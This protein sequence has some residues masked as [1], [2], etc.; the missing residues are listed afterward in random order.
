MNYLESSLVSNSTGSFTRGSNTLQEGPE[1]PRSSWV[2]I[3]PNFPTDPAREWGVGTVFGCGLLSGLVLT[4]LAAALW[5]V[6][7]K[8]PS[9]Y[10]ETPR[11]GDEP[12]EEGKAKQT[13]HLFSHRCMWLTALLMTQSFSAVV[14]SRFAELLLDH[15]NLIYFLTM[16]VGAGGSAGAQS[17]VLV[18]RDLAMKAEV[19]KLDQVVMGAKIAIVLAL[20]ATVRT[21][22]SAVPAYEIVAIV[23]ALVCIIMVSVVVGTLLPLGMNYSGI[24]PAHSL[25]VVQVIMDITGVAIVCTIGYFLLD[26]VLDAPNEN[27]Q[28]HFLTR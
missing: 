14:L 18:V 22:V 12:A 25:P 4:L 26:R 20:V 10:E 1:F 23:S 8:H 21:L 6:I 15:P 2:L 16:L 24:D 27:A 28:Q 13:M 9:S 5:I 3:V 19:S 7:T 11:A 17:A